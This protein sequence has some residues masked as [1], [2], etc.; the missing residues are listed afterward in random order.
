M[1][2][3]LET[4]NR[5]E[6]PRRWNQQGISYPLSPLNPS[7]PSIEILYAFINIGS[8]NLVDMILYMLKVS[9]KNTLFYELFIGNHSSIRKAKMMELTSSSIVDQQ[10]KRVYQHLFWRYHRAELPNGVLP[11]KHAQSV[12]GLHRQQLV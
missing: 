6:N 5:A 7:S 8:S 2:S 11:Q 3:P 4:E 9:L 12:L 1:Q 10:L